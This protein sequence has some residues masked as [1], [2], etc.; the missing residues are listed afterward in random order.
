MARAETGKQP[1]AIALLKQDHRTVEDLFEQFENAKGAER[2][3]KLAEKICL[4]L[5]IHTRIEEEI[6]YPACKGAVEEDLLKEG[7]VEHDS[8]KVLM[9]E[10]EAGSPDDEFYDSKMK[11]LS[12]LI[13]HHVKEEERRMD[14]MFA[15]ARRSDLDLDELGARLRARKQALQQEFEEDGTPAPKP[16]TLEHTTVG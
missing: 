1:D 6:F 13:E 11:V 15:Q 10:I 14:G 12:E 5:T 4:E 7:Y 16:S 8:A 3:R 9:A 2:K